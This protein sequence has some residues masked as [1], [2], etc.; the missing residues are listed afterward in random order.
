MH[1]R[2]RCGSELGPTQNRLL[3]PYGSHTLKD[4]PLSWNS[5]CTLSP[6]AKSRRTRLM[7]TP[8]QRA[9]YR[10]TLRELRKNEFG[11]SNAQSSPPS[12]RNGYVFMAPNGLAAQLTGAALLTGRPNRLDGGHSLPRL[13]RPRAAP[14]QLQPRVSQPA[15]QEATACV[16]CLPLELPTQGLAE[17]LLDQRGLRGQH[18][19][20]LETARETTCS[21]APGRPAPARSRAGRWRGQPIPADPQRPFG[22]GA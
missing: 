2:C 15:C 5:T 11:I 1:A 19:A 17:H 7:E 13:D 20:R 9:K 6:K 22:R 21:Q 14:G 8:G 12:F 3:S 16:P 4:S 18:P 10:A